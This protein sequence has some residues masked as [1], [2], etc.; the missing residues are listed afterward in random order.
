MIH[1]KKA[2]VQWPL[3]ALFFL[4]AVALLVTN[5]AV[6]TIGNNLGENQYRI[7]TKTEEAVALEDYIS[8]SA[9]YSAQLTRLAF[10]RSAGISQLTPSASSS[11]SRCG[12][13]V[14]PNYNSKTENCLPRYEETITQH[15]NHYLYSYLQSYTQ[16]PLLF[17]YDLNIVQQNNQELALQSSGEELSLPFVKNTSST[18][19]DPLTCAQLSQLQKT[20]PKTA[21]GFY[22][23]EKPVLC[24]TGECFSQVALLLYETYQ[25]QNKNYAY[26]VGGESPYCPQHVLEQANLPTQNFF[27]G[28]SISD[29]RLSM[30]ST[31]APGFDS[32]GWAWWAGKHATV[33]F[34][35][36]RL[37]SAQYYEKAKSSFLCEGDA[38]TLSFVVAQSQP[39][40]ILFVRDQQRIAEDGAT[41]LSGSIYLLIHVGLDEKTGRILVVHADPLK[42][43]I[44]EFLP[45]RFA[46][47]EQS[48]IAGVYR[49]TYQPSGEAQLPEDVQLIPPF[50][51]PFAWCR[52]AESKTP[53]S[54]YLKQLQEQPFQSTHQTYFDLFI[55]TALAEGIDPALLATHAVLESS[56][57][58]NDACT[59]KQKS[60]LTGCG[61]YP[62][63]SS[64]CACQN[65]FVRTDETQMT[66]TAET[67]LRAYEAARTGIP[68]G[69]GL[70]H[71]CSA[72]QD[73][74]E[75]FWNCIFCIYQ[76]NYEGIID[77]GNYYF[78]RDKTCD[79]AEKAK[80]EYCIWRQYFDAEWDDLSL[81]QSYLTPS[82][83]TFSPS[84]SATT[85]L[86]LPAMKL[87]TD[88][89]VPSLLSCEDNLETCVQ[90]KLQAF[91]LQHNQQVRIV[92]MEN[93]H[94]FATTLTE[95]L[96]DC[97][98]NEQKN[99][100]CP[101]RPT[102][103]GLGTEKQTIDLLSNGELKV[104]N[105]LLHTFSFN[106][107]FIVSAPTK[108]N[109]SARIISEAGKNATFQLFDLGNVSSGTPQ[110]LT[111]QWN[112]ITPYQ[113]DYTQAGLPVLGFGL[114]K[115]SY[116]SMTWVPYTQNLTHLTCKDNK[117]YFSFQAIIL[118]T[119]DRLNF[120]LYL[121]DTTPEEL[122]P[123]T[124]ADVGA[125]FDIPSSL[126]PLD[127]SS[128]FAHL[129]S[130]DPL[131]DM[132]S[133]L[134]GDLTILGYSPIVTLSWQVSSPKHY[135]HSFI[136]ELATDASFQSILGTREI[137]AA[138]ALSLPEDTPP[139]LLE[140]L[141]FTSS[142][143][144][145][146]FN[147]KLNTVSFSGQ[148]LN[149]DTTY[150]YRI[151]P[152]DHYA[153]NGT[154]STP[155]SFNFTD[156]LVDAL[157]ITSQQAA[158]LQA[159]T[160][161]MTQGL[162]DSLCLYNYDWLLDSDDVLAEHQGNLTI[163]P[164]E[165]IFNKSDLLYHIEDIPQI[166]CDETDTQV[167]KICAGNK[168]LVETL[169]AVSAG[170]EA[171]NWHMTI[172]QAYRNWDIQ[173]RL[174]E[175]S[176]FDTSMACNPGDKHDP[177]PC[178]HMIAGAID[179][180]IFDAS[181]QRLS[182]EAQEAFMCRYGFVRYGKEWWHFEIGTPKWIKAEEA[183]MS[184][185]CCY[186]GVRHPDDTREPT[187][188]I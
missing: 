175:R 37:G 45:E 114:F 88:E 71:E 108:F 122:G 129:L 136:V 110:P 64:G 68:A 16:T 157:P 53:S 123:H 127:S 161:F 83:L 177:F 1:T 120:S 85:R 146:T 62:S 35:E 174:Y 109:N 60:S 167:G 125:C 86:N 89:F 144:G 154:S 141:T 103:I 151:T 155:Q 29:E 58:K 134:D 67:D 184:S 116:S 94:L 102:H 92:R 132:F 188:R 148:P 5:S 4:V 69:S 138:T 101:L 87:I 79:Y 39:G 8:L 27:S 11:S 91:N 183:R 185:D 17:L 75:I 61:W 23:K 172:T 142:S 84:F 107:A 77:G 41:I 178:P 59:S 118:S 130:S 139:P 165:N 22:G 126:S 50:V 93:K 140:Q 113:D 149:K 106:P 170:L 105:Q 121:E 182:P 133:S 99:C 6:T 159:G 156:E 115:Q 43:L 46:S 171:N 10:L 26:V 25:L 18:R 119:N 81:L 14:S 13:Y 3:V 32:S 117:H 72:Y 15:F 36:E 181:N 131:P 19:S 180:T 54:T 57:G 143:Q 40:D 20:Y 187:C 63:C 137:L 128:L 24:S 28:V 82:E 168:A 2:G 104:D 9:K 73:S 150:Y 160:S 70:Y 44:K 90:A 12:L 33:P 51:G 98:Y 47:G 112:L 95:S 65:D 7:L 42:G 100:I 158:L 135:Y 176:G 147:Y 21:L 49:P 30:R 179:L 52:G 96:L 34:F 166:T 56:M 153:Q 186:Y 173:Y 169:Y 31:L 164:L 97:R 145:T 162:K 38:C 80:K 152:V 74:P 66:C 111:Q 55:A 48:L 163:Y 124:S 76:G 78:T